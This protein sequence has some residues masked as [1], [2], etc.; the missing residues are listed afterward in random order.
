MPIR[1]SDDG[2]PRNRRPPRFALEDLFRGKTA[3]E[4]RAIYKD[5][6]DWGPDVGCERV[7]EE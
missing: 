1:K 6:Y 4:W 5:A 3:E 7:D 2:S